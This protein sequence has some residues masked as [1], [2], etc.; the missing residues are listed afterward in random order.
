MREDSADWRVRS[1]MRLTL[2]ALAAGLLLAAG[3]APA[4]AARVE[5][6]ETVIQYSA[7]AGDVVDVTLAGSPPNVPKA[8]RSITFR[9]G[10]GGA[11]PTVGPGCIVLGGLPRCQLAIATLLRFSTLEGDDKI[12]VSGAADS[13]LPTELR[14]GDGADTLTGG[15]FVDTVFAG[16]GGDRLAG[17][18]A[19]DQLHGEGGDDVFTGLDDADVVDGGPGTDLLDSRPSP[20]ACASRSTAR[21]TTASSARARPWRSRTCAA[22]PPR[23]SSSAATGATSCAARAATTSSWCAAAASTWSTAAQARIAWRPTRPTS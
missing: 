8:S 17:G 7:A 23:T 18:G 15:P 10:A 16:A 2:I 20:Q 5:R 3:A 11:A 1:G 22:R 6:L 21:P 12:D 13:A 4:S 19:A 9:R 14:T